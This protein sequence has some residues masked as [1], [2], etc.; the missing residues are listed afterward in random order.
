MFRW[1]LLFCLYLL[2]LFLLF[3]FF[4]YWLIIGIGVDW[5]NCWNVVFW[6]L[7]FFLLILEIDFVFLLRLD[8]LVWYDFVDKS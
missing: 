3:V 7:D 2:G 5:V 1:Y 8:G 4:Y 6:L